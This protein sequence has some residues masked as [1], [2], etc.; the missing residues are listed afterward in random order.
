MFL[1]KK[2]NTHTLCFRSQIKTSEVVGSKLMEKTEA[3]QNCYIFT[4]EKIKYNFFSHVKI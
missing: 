4:C 1:I 3:I 2:I